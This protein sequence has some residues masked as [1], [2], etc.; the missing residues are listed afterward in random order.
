MGWLAAQP[1][2]FRAWVATVARW[3]DYRLGQQIFMAGD[4]SDGL[5]G[6]AGGGIELTCPLLA[7]EHVTV[8]RGEVGFWIGDS[9]ELSKEPR[10]VTMSA[11]TDCRLLHIP[12]LAVH[13]LLKEQ[14]QFWE[15]F[16]RLS[17]INNQT[18]V[19]LLAETLSLS[20]R[21]RICRR[22]LKLAEASDDVALTQDQ[23]AKLLG[24]VRTT[25]SN[26]LGKLSAA[27][28]IGVGDGKLRVLRRDILERYVDEQ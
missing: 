3:R 19:T 12:H 13:G 4:S 18:A 21:A 24:L 23:L 2:S 17:H 1:P 16:Y 14:P 28:A 8:Y 7:E 5:Y 20:V 22:V 6:L 11:A 27:G 10:L 15:C 9:A 26:E 25:V